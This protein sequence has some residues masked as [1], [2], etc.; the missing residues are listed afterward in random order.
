[1]L[2]LTAAGA[3]DTAWGSSGLANVGVDRFSLTRAA[4]PTGDGGVVLA[5]RVGQS[6]GA[7]ADLG[8]VKFTAAGAP[9]P[10]FGTSGDGIV[11]PLLNGSHEE[12]TDVV[13][14]PDGKIVVLVTSL[15]R[16]SWLARYLPS[17]Q[18]DLTFGTNGNAQIT[19]PITGWALA[20]QADG[21]LWVAGEVGGAGGADYGLVRFTAG[22]Q[23][24]SAFNNGSAL[25]IDFFGGF[26]TPGA[27][28]MQPDGKPVLAGRAASGSRMGAGFA[29]VLP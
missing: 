28:L 4:A 1:M 23:P 11:R 18:P 2:K 8:L 14:Q 27:L 16:A 24:D 3:I 21:S 26:D 12:A 10:T 13:V 7:L 6:G 20:L 17:G 25:V 29:R 15:V 19:T 22:G 9:D 5:G